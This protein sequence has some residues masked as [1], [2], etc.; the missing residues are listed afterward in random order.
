[1]YM[2]VADIFMW[3]TI[4]MYYNTVKISCEAPFCW[5]N[6]LQQQFKLASSLKL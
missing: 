4:F 3:K 2:S 5:H 6:E 1:M